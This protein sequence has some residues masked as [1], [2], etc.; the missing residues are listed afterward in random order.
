MLGM[1]RHLSNQQLKDVSEKIRGNALVTAM[2][3]IKL[4]QVS[5]YAKNTEDGTYFFTPC[6][7][8]LEE[9]ISGKPV[10]WLSPVGGVICLMHLG[11]ELTKVI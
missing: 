8:S 5:I 1:S 9:F 10:R 6:H 2:K 4:E 3:P 7:F 11:Q